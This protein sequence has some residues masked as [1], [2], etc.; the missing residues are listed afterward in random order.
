QRPGMHAGR[1]W[2][3]WI[4]FLSGPAPFTYILPVIMACLVAGTVAQK[5]MGLYAATQV[6]FSSPVLWLGP[7]PV[8]GL[9]VW[10]GLVFVNLLFKLVFKSPWTP[11]RAGTVLAHGAV[12]FL[13][14]GG[15]FTALSGREGYMDLA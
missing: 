2:R 6:F 9:P 13:L 8:P 4:A 15:M 5:H 1:T 11:Q 7:V 12:L 10:L 3:G 14:L